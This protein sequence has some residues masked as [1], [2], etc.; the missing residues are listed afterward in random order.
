MVQQAFKFGAFAFDAQKSRLTRHGEL[1]AIGQRAAGILVRLLQADGAVVSKDDLFAAAWP[2]QLVEESNLSVQI[3]ALRKAL[4][5]NAVGEDWITTVQRLGYRFATESAG[6][7]QGQQTAE[8]K[9]SIAVLPFANSS[10]QAGQDFFA[11]GLT[12]DIITD[13]SNVPGFRVIARNSTLVY[14]GKPTD[15]RQ[16]AQDLN[17]DYVVEGSVRKSA[18]RIRV[19]VQLVDATSGTHVWAERFD[20]ELSDVF[21]LQ[22]E[23]ARRIVGA[24]S[25]KLTG[26]SFLR[27]RPKSLE[28]Y[29]LCLR[30]R[31]MVEQSKEA[32]LEA[33]RFL[34]RAI[35]LEPDY[36]EA[37]CRLAMSYIF[38]GLNYSGDVNYYRAKSLE[39]AERAVELD[40]TSSGAHTYLGY[41]Q[42]YERQPALANANF[43]KAIRLNPNDADAR[44]MYSDFLLLEGKPLEA[45]ETVREGMKLNPNPAGW[46]YWLLGQALVQLGRY[47]EAVKVLNNEQTY[48]TASRRIL[49]IALSRLGRKEEAKTEVELFLATYPDAKTSAW[50]ATRPFRNPQDLKFWIHAFR[51]L[52]LPE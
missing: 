7:A 29:E 42:A 51:E 36:A 44:A 38:H 39:A 18:D 15:V 41:I 25:G 48:R 50:E 45:V 3:A 27:N 30:C 6:S 49:A 8:A 35:E 40:P 12:E 22:D 46:Y 17:V 34:L 16:I 13:I 32:N 37:Y 14:K 23:V 31:Y 1:I 52:G 21:A 43:L 2:G 28:A 33:Q 10:G 26:E 47:E 20:R 11:D 4:G 9:P 24:I 19:N 5:Q